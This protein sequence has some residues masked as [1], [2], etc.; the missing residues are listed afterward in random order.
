MSSLS[1]AMASNPFALNAAESL[2]HPQQTSAVIHRLPPPLPV[3][4]HSIDSLNW[5]STGPDDLSPPV[6]PAGEDD[7]V[8][9]DARMPG[10][11]GVVLDDGAP[12][13]VSRKAA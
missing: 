3:P 13:A 9:V 2:A 1:T 10:S 12:L 8:A 5:Y 11:A 4:S 6:A 7:G